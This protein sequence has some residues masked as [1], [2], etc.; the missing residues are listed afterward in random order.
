MCMDMID[1]YDKFK[2]GTI[3]LDNVF[4]MVPSLQGSLFVFRVHLLTTQTKSIIGVMKCTNGE[5]HSTYHPDHGGI[6]NIVLVMKILRGY[7][8]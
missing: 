8:F 2:I 5:A 4:K 7:Y 6:L 3:S 1:N